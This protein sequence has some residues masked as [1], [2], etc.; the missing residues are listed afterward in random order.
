MSKYI[1]FVT[2]KEQ[3]NT[4]EQLLIKEIN[5]LRYFFI[6]HFILHSSLAQIMKTFGQLL[7]L[8][9]NP[10]LVSLS[11]QLI[12]FKVTIGVIH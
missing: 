3:K 1:F 5:L 9:Y 10:I 4:T 6:I 11:K 2:S 12:A 8:M 7:Q